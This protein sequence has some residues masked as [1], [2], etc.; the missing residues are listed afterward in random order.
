MGVVVCVC[1]CVCV[2]GC[3][4]VC[5]WCIVCYLFWVRLQIE[6]FCYV[7]THKQNKTKNYNTYTH[8]H[9]HTHTH[10]PVFLIALP[11]QIVLTYSTH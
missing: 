3:V 10:T 5:V 9:T 1:V 11:T 8:M 4:F 6:K 2:C 7:C